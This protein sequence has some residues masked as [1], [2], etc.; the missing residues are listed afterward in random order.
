METPLLNDL[1]ISYY[2]AAQCSST[3][4]CLFIYFS[5]FKSEFDLHK[6]LF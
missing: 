6:S 5:S 4:D 3:A 2:Q 1:K